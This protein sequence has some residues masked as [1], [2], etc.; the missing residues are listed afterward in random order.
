[1]INH[2]IRR[3]ARTLPSRKLTAK[4][5]SLLFMGMAAD[6]KFIELGELIDL[7]FQLVDEGLDLLEVF[8]GITVIKPSGG[9]VVDL[10]ETPEG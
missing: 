2:A 6:Q 3:E 9:L 8:L 1:M 7:D 10:V 5:G 4:D